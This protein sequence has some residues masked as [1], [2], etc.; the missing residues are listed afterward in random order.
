MA[1]T[2]YNNLDDYHRALSSFDPMQS[3]GQMP[4]YSP[5]SG[6]GTKP[7]VASSYSP[8]GSSSSSSPSASGTP[9]VPSLGGSTTPLSGAL[10]PSGGGTSPTGGSG[11][12]SPGTSGTLNPFT[13]ASPP[14]SGTGGG[15]PGT[16]FTNSG[17]TGMNTGTG[18]FNINAPQYSAYS[19]TQGAGPNGGSSATNFNPALGVQAGDYTTTRAPYQLGGEQQSDVNAQ[20]QL[21]VIGQGNPF[22][23]SS[24]AWANTAGA[25]A[26]GQ[27]TAAIGQGNNMYNASNAVLNTAFDPQQA[28]Y[29]RMQQQNSDQTNAAEAQRGITMSPYGAGVANQSNTNF[30]IDWQNQQLGRQTQGLQAAGQGNTTGANLGSTGVNQTMSA[31]QMPYNAAQ[32]GLQNTEQ[33]IQDYLA[34]LGKG[35]AGDAGYKTLVQPMPSIQQSYPQYNQAGWQMM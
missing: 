27:G 16:G 28:L 33:T 20:A 25:Q 35:Q 13:L 1:L 6:S 3:G 14:S 15:S 17:S 12:S 7:N 18:G 31:G 11:A 24:Q 34:Y 4:M 22:Q 26:A 8:T 2:Y 10:P 32:Q 30:N 29:Q 21:N 19:P 5:Q 9:V 23:Q